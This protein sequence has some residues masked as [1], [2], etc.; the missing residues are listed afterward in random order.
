MFKEDLSFEKVL[1]IKVDPERIERVKKLIRFDIPDLGEEVKN[2][3]ISQQLQFVNI[4]YARFMAGVKFT[5]QDV[6]DLLEGAIDCHAHGGSDPF[7]RLLLEDEI[8]FD[9]SRAKMRAVVFKTWFTPSA[10][11]IPIVKKYLDKWADENRLKPVE[12]FG[13]ITL[14]YSVG[15]LNPDAVKRCLGFP[16]FKYVWM[17]MVDSY[18]H[19]RVVYDDWSGAG[20]KLLDEKG[21]VFPQLTEILKICADHDLIV[22]SGHYPYSD[23]KVMMEEAKRVGVKRMEIIHPAHIHSKTL[24]S[25]MKEA[26]SEGIKLMLSGL[27][28]TTFPLHETGPVYAVRIIKEVGADHL[29]YGSD[30]GQIHNPTHLV[31]T[32]WTIKLL[33]AY[34]ATKEEVK[35]VFQTTPARHLGLE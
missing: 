10:S 19:R 14:N 9:Y 22:G 20:I 6:K 15:G 27:G 1:T 12:I 16:G 4:Q 30:Y 18:H 11:R 34:G 7:D 8:A 32:E 35:K 24:I 28:T 2:F 33:L 3:L 21:K 13:G 31:G 5:Q 25:E 17:P 29:V 26:A 23:T